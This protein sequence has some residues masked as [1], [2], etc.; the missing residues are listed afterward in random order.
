MANVIKFEALEVEVLI[1]IANESAELVESSARKTVEHAERCGR[2]LIAA[3][4]K[5]P[6]GE[7]SSWLGQNFDYSQEHARRYMTI[8]SNSTR[9]LNLKD[10]TSIREALR[11]I[12]DDP[13]TPKRERKS[14]VEVIEVAADE[15]ADDVPVAAEIVTE[16]KPAVEVITA[17]AA[18][19]PAK[20]KASRPKKSQPV[21]PAEP[22][23][24]FDQDEET[25][26]ITDAMEKHLDNWP[27][28][29]WGSE[30]YRFLCTNV[31]LCISFYTAYPRTDADELSALGDTANE[32][33]SQI[34]AMLGNIPE[35]DRL[36]VWREIVD[37]LSAQNPEHWTCKS[38]E[39]Q[40]Q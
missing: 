17:V 8:A 29:Q 15:P 1:G 16:N 23:P 27:N 36:F 40:A 24:E 21:A 2:A 13:D 38:T 14:S 6:H 12:A 4:D 3:K 31:R 19:K 30:A 11:M 26:R 35:S 22:H 32:I 28:I 33:S 25:T 7:W 34:R 37:S 5:V 9:V 18:V 39:S 10:A 20:V